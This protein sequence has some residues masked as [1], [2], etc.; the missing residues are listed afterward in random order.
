MHR[1][2]SEQVVMQIDIVETNLMFASRLQRVLK[3][4]GHETRLF[5]ST[6]QLLHSERV[7]DVVLVNVGHAFFDG[8]AVVR[9]LR[10][11]GIASVI[12][13]YAGH[14]EKEKHRL[15]LEA[16]C[17]LTGTNRQ[18]TQRLEPLIQR[19]VRLSHKSLDRHHQ[20]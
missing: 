5:G 15:A 18:V 4:L 9:A 14:R 3:S 16:G 13:G 7:P 6:E 17:D 20:S 8:L 12:I 10:E 19:A 11:A 2:E 1:Q